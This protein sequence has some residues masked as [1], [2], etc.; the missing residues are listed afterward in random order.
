MGVPVVLDPVV[1]LVATTVTISIAWDREECSFMLV[2]AVARFVF[3]I[4]KT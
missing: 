2:Q 3:P 4:E 1:V